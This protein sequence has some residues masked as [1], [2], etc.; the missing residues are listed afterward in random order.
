[1]SEK[2]IVYWCG[3]QEGIEDTDINEDMLYYEPKNLYKDLIKYKN[4]NLE[5]GSDGNMFL[6]PSFQDKALKTYFLENTL[7]SKVSVVD[8]VLN[9]TSETTVP[10][11]YVR[12]NNFNNSWHLLFGLSW[13]FFASEP[14]EVSFTSPYFHKTAYMNYMQTV[15]GKFDIGQWFRPYQMEFVLWNTTQDIILE[16]GDPLV[17]AEFHTNKKIEFQRFRY[18]KEFTPFW[19]ACTSAPLRYGRKKSL[20]ERYDRFIKGDMNKS[21]L[22]LINKNLI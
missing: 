8:G 12:K 14:L 5:D 9:T 18:T 19:G 15:P 16:A 4:P 6:C 3:R 17:Y 20:C 22:Q 11:G 21:I 1:M 10:F 2:I 13:L 7:T